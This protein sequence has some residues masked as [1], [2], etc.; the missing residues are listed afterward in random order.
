[1]RE[2]EIEFEDQEKSQKDMVTP[3]STH[4]WEIPWTEQPGGL[5]Y[6]VL[7][8]VTHNFTSNT[9]TFTIFLSGKV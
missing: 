8:T 3:S 9:F 1:M 5:Q 4:A 2:M 6:K 7:Q